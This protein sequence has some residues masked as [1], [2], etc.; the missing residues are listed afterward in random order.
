MARFPRSAI[1]IVVVLLVAA[2]C[3]PS[4]APRGVRGLPPERSWSLAEAESGPEVD[5]LVG[6]FYS[7]PFDRE[8]IERELGVA[9]DRYPGAAE[10]HE[11]AALLATLRDDDHE[12]WSHW[13]SAAADLRS[14]FTELYLWLAIDRELT[15]REEFA[16]IELLE[17]IADRHPRAVVRQVARVALVGHCRW[18]GR[19]DDARRRTA[20]LG[21]IESW[22]VVGPF[23]NDQGG[24]FRTR[25]GPEEGV[26]LARAYQGT[27]M[28]VRWATV[29]QL[30]PVG[31]VPL[32]WIF[33]PTGSVVAYLATFVR[34]AEPAEVSLRLTVDTAVRAWVNGAL[35]LSEEH[36]SGAG[37]ENVV[38]PV[39]LERGWNELLIK[40]ADRGET[41]WRVG[42]RFTDAAGGAVPGLQSS[43]RPHPVAARATA[44]GRGGIMHAERR[45]LGRELAAVSPPARRT[46]L[47]LRALAQAGLDRAALRRSRDLLAALP[48]HP[49][50]IHDGAIEHEIEGEEGRMIELLNRGV[51]L[52]GDWAAAFLR[53]R[54]EFYASTGMVDRALDDLG[55]AVEIAP[56]SR[57]VRLA[58]SSAYQEESWPEA[59][60]R[61][62]EALLADWPDSGAAVLGLAAVADELGYR[63]RAEG[64]YERSRSLEPGYPASIERLLGFAVDRGDLERGLDLAE[65]LADLEPARDIH[66]LTR[67]DL[68]RI[69]GRRDEARQVLELVARRRP[70]WAEPH[71]RLAAMAD[72]DGEIDAA[73]AG[74]RRALDRDP[75]DSRL[76][77]RIDLLEA[78]ERIGIWRHAP[79]DAAVD[80]AV[81]RAR[82][83]EVMPG[84]DV[85]YLLD[86][87]VTAV[88]PNG[89][90]DGLVTQVWL[91]VTTDGRDYLIGHYLR[92]YS[93]LL[94]AYMVSPDGS[95]QEPS[96]IRSDVVRFSGVEEG[97]VTVVQ[98]VYHDPGGGFLP[99]DYFADW[100]F[101]ETN[102]QTDRARWRLIVP[103]GERLALRVAGDVEREESTEGG[104]RVL[105]FT[106][107]GVP[108]LVEETAMVPTIDLLRQVNV[109]TV[110]S[111][112]EYVEW[113]LA[114]MSEAFE[115]NDEI[116]AL[117]RRLTEGAASRRE[118]LDRLYR[119]VAQEIRYQ[120]DYEDTIAGVRPHSAPVVLERGYGDCKDKAVLLV[121]LARAVDL[122]L[123]FA[124]LRT[125]DAGEVI[126]EIPNQQF[127]HAIVYVPVQD[128]IDDAFFMDA[129]TDG[130]D[131]GNLRDDD[132]G[133]LAL[134]IDP[135][136]ERHHFV[137]IPHQG[138]EHQTYRESVAIDL[139]SATEATA[140]VSIEARGTYA[141]QVRLDARNSE[142]L[143]QLQEETV[144][145]LFGAGTIT[146]SEIRNHDDIVRPVEL[147][148]A[149][150]VS[151]ALQVDGREVILPLPT[152]FPEGEE[153]L[154]AARQTPLRLPPP[155][156][157]S[158]RVALRLPRGA[159]VAAAPAAVTVEHPCFTMRRR[160]A[161][162]GATLAVEDDYRRTC[163][164]VSPA[165]Y[166]AL[167][168][169]SQQ[170][171]T[172]LDDTVTIELAR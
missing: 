61:E 98:F 97:S 114:L 1:A 145:A 20:Q 172:Q 96:S 108:P 58:L 11:V 82:S 25:F 122:D 42:A 135:R 29:E 46:A 13:M 34:S 157:R 77:E 87:E 9:L 3:G 10:L 89:N 41:V 65:A 7:E 72:E 81:A 86:D 30:D 52:A 121:T 33:E 119:F 151:G 166:P 37:P 56:R 64:L 4:R 92:P 169:A 48:G 117:A 79:G 62:L 99:N 159:R 16:T 24:G 55:R 94:Q 90:A 27:S 155:E 141:A 102:V 44:E 35:V 133:A 142:V 74:W 105:T 140:A 21:V 38:V 15:V 45:L 153:T 88:R 40:S 50:A 2:A 66:A 131:L 53:R 165:D 100:F 71:R 120:Q 51:E 57:S 136:T 75:D 91:A 39:R 14:P 18:L 95:R 68:L 67:A 101:Q 73:V 126:R 148:L 112:Q 123:H 85:V 104:A 69:G 80:A 107:T 150:D 139:R 54:A 28:P 149:V 26:D 70:T 23:D 103:E 93:R 164:E 171:S 12:A 32:E 60:G 129:T 158:L 146:A 5:A 154:L 152:A 43:S 134:V 109:S 22:Q 19:F 31:R 132:Q 47:E 6:R 36:V 128:G 84:A 118:A 161:V 147:G 63:D 116:A 163:T 124:V 162:A 138:P 160:V 17:Q 143:R 170:A 49:L 125:R 83:V 8:G 167:R 59:S 111:W 168:R 110:A 78:R 113:E 127:N 144:A 106:A 137:R 130:L 76:A 115:T 156:T